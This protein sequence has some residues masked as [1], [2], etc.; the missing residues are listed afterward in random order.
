[1]FN[2]LSSV[3]KVSKCV[4]IDVVSGVKKY[5]TSKYLSVRAHTGGEDRVWPNFLRAQIPSN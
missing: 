3:K 5:S 2:C 4:W 1:M